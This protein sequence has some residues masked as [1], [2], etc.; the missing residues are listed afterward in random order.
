[1]TKKPPKRPQPKARRPSRGRGPSPSKPA[2]REEAGRAQREAPEP[3]PPAGPAAGDALPVVGI[4]ASAGGLEALEAFLRHVPESSGIAWV[5]VQHLDPKDRGA[6]VGLLQR[7]TPMPVAQVSDR[8]PVEADHVYVIPPGRDMAM[9]NGVLHLVPQRSPRGLNLP[10]DAFFRSLAAERQER[11]VAV[12]LSG[13]GSDGTLGL[14]AIKERGGAAFVQALH[15]AKFDGMPRSALDTGLVDVVGSAEELPARI[16]AYLRHHVAEPQG[17]DRAQGVLEK[18]FLV[19]RT[20]TGNDFTQYKRSTIH[21]RIERRMGLHQVDRLG[22]YLRFLRE[23]PKEVELLFKELLIGVTSFF[24]D[25]SSWEVLEKEVLPDLVAAR[26]G[27]GTLRAWVPG[28]STGEEAYS[29]AISLKEAIAAK[30]LSSHLGVQIFATD[31]DADAIEKAR[32]GTYPANIAADVPPDRLRRYFVQDDRG[33]RVSK[34]VRE[35]VVFAPQNLAMDPPFTKLDLLSCRN[36]LIYLSA[37]LQK[38][39]IPLFHYSL[40]PGGV[41]FLGSAETVGGFSTLFQPHDAKTRIYRRLDAAL[42]TVP[43][44]F[45]AIFAPPLPPEGDGPRS[46]AAQPPSPPPNLQAM[47]ERLIVQRFAPT[48]ILTTAKGDVLYTSGR[49]GKYL[50]PTV[51]R[52]NL[53]VFAMAREG[54]R[55]ELSAA[56]AT[57]LKEDRPVTV[58]GARVGTNGGSQ[59]VDVTVQRLAEPKELR[60]TVIVVISDVAPPLPGAPSGAR[61]SPPS[62]RAA[63]LER[64]LQQ[65]RE[66]VQTTREEMQTSQEELKSMNEELQ[67]TNEELQS[68]NE[69]LTT[70]KEEMQ[71]MNEELQTVNHEL[72][73]KVDELSRSNNDMKNLLN[74]TD[75]ATLFLDEA[76]HVRRFTTQTSRIIKLIPGDT[77]RPVTDIATELDYADL[78]DDAREVLRSLVFKEKQVPARNGRWFTVRILPYRTLENVIDG[79]VITFTDVTDTKVLEERLRQQAAELRQ[80]TDALPSFVWASRPDGACEYLSQG[81]I[82]YT[83]VSEGEQLGYGWLEQVHPEDREKLREAWRGA[84]RE[85]TALDLDVRIRGR[86]GDHR[87]FKTRAVPIRDE[88]GTLVKWYGTH[89]DVDALKRTS[90]AEIPGAGEGG[91][92]G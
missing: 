75:I 55:Y 60:N 37:E 50:E 19:L 80:M 18:I 86:R 30:K 69:E 28:C 4:G 36:L 87:W 46:A 59:H 26:A 64:E 23:N 71:S 76:L 85:G 16:V 78:A 7:A 67:S 54:L 3:Q 51:G 17:D 83:G 6:M 92:T 65:A 68:T 15:S 1:M 74:S 81:W 9:L 31:L 84:L 63:E 62:A 42:A 58:R 91:T 66:E 39:I 5:I 53:N 22:T 29:L 32:L 34:E 12:V 45:P 10:V 82:H 38:R 47:A 56:F 49:T 13:M 48:A 14:R 11:A 25:P 8:M 73:A 89:T 27:A 33:Y 21:R 43:V 40:L 24:R 77:G 61:R 79:V 90:V 44:E 72:Q 41:L 88:Q 52:A 20:Q 57:A 35:C 2:A 70:S